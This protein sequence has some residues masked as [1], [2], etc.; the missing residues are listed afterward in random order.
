MAFPRE[1]WRCNP[2]ERLNREVRRRT[3]VVGA[4]TDGR[5]ALMLVA[6]RLG[7]MAGTKWGLRRYLDMTRLD[8]PAAE[9]TPDLSSKPETIA[10]A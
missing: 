9:P 7:H 5:S 2:L 10:A 8:P 6:A 1:H 3:R 4:F